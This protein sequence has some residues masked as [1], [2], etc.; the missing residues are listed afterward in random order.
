MPVA[1]A[2]MTPVLPMLLFF[3]QKIASKVYP[4]KKEEVRKEALM[5][6]MEESSANN[7]LNS[8]IEVGLGDC[9]KAPSIYPS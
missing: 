6:G 4:K 7:S 5:K 3:G 1:V 9:V 8:F 2:I